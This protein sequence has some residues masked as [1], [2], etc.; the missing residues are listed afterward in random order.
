MAP[1]GS[2]AASFSAST[3][4]PPPYKVAIFT[5][6][7]VMCSKEI[8]LMSSHQRFFAHL[9]AERIG[10]MTFQIRRAPCIHPHVVLDITWTVAVQSTVLCLHLGKMRRAGA[11]SHRP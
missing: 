5:E 8:V 10:I 2:Q 4:E 11:L 9:R 1:V 6:I 7:A 3:V